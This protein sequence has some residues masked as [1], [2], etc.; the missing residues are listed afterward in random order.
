VNGNK[1]EIGEGRGRSNKNVWPLKRRM[2]LK[3]SGIEETEAQQETAN[4]C[5]CESFNCKPELYF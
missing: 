5:F 4:L 3:G 1:A 2:E